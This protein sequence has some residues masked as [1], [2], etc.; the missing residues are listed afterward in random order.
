MHENLTRVAV[1]GAG[2][3]GLMVAHT[4]NKHGISVTVFEKSR[5]VGGRM[6]TRRMNDVLTFD[7]GAQYFT[8][9]DEGF[10]N[11]VRQWQ[12]KGLVDCWDA[13]ICILTSGRI[14]R[15]SSHVVRFIGIPG[16]TSICKHLAETIEVRLHTEIASL[17]I[18]GKNWELLDN[19]H[20]SQGNFD[21]VISSAPGTQSARLLDVVPELADRASHVK[22]HPCWALMTSFSSPLPLSYNGAF[23]N[24]SAIS[25]I[26]RNSSKPKRYSS[27]DCWVLHGSGSW[28]EDQIETD[29][30]EIEDYMLREFWE[31]TGLQPIKPQSVAVHRWRY[32]QPLEP[33]ED[34]CLFDSASGLGACGDWCCQPRVEGAY[35]SGIA[36]A[37][38]VLGAVNADTG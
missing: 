2:I 33:L 20:V 16:M 32:A 5:G 35:L 12:R 34:L 4:L 23:V 28:S 29:H 18:D 1:I 27:Q 36:L 13:E 26:A 30:K 21:F 19:D 24:N 3:S 38:H 10:A 37:D 22:M 11:S 31:I 6:A 15:D 25:W 17:R 14:E 7:H 9:S 8:V